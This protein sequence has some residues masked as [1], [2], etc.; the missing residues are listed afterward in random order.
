MLKN[1]RSAIG[2]ATA[3]ALPLLIPPGHALSQDANPEAARKAIPPDA[4]RKQVIGWYECAHRKLTILPRDE[5]LVAVFEWANRAPQS[6]GTIE[7]DDESRVTFVQ[8]T[9]KES[10][11]AEL[12]DNQLQ[13][14]KVIKLTFRKQAGLSGVVGAY[15]NEKGQ[16]MTIAFRDK[17]V[18][19]SIEWGNNA[20]RTNGWLRA[21]ASGATL[22]TGFK[23]QEAVDLTFEEG[24]VQS[25]KIGGI[26]FVRVDPRAEDESNR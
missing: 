2:V 12:R 19:C 16:T 17:N 11:D 7:V 18:A 13:S 14:L 24:V 23:W 6:V 20:P 4:V 8:P 15:V 1:Y 10:M 21:D 22:L 9:S 26:E 25:I 5:D 3:L